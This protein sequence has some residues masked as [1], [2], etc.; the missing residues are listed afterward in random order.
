MVEQLLRLAELRIAAHRWRIAAIHMEDQYVVLAYA[1]R[2]QMDR[3]AAQGGGRLRI[4]DARTAYL[5][6]NGSMT[7][8]EAVRREVKSLLQAE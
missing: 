6:M 8:R 5:P 7:T 1:S 2:P 3:L 4:V